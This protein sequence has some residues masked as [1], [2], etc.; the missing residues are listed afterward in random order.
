MDSSYLAPQRFRTLSPEKYSFGEK[1]TFLAKYLIIPSKHIPIPKIDNADILEKLVNTQRERSILEMRLQD[2]KTNE[3]IRN[4]I[5]FI[6]IHLKST[7]LT[8]ENTIDEQRK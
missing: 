8:N 3:S 4:K 7:R 5:Y 6:E 1:N 2:I